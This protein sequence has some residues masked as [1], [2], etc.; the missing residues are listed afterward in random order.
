MLTIVIAF[1]ANLLVAVAKSV[2]AALTGPA[3][4]TA[5]AAHSWAD[6]SNEVFLIIADKRGVA[7]GSGKIDSSMSVKRRF[8]GF[9]SLLRRS[10]SGRLGGPCSV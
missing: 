8:G 9:C 5:E 2:A 1:G 3:S 7:S 4:M 6:T 10:G